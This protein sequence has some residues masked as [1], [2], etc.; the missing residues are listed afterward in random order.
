MRAFCDR[1]CEDFQQRVHGCLRHGF[2]VAFATFTGRLLS[3]CVS[4][5]VTY[6]YP[7]IYAQ[8]LRADEEKT[9]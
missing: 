5:R 3:V 2:R 1:L 7:S 6:L 4:M 8:V 9:V